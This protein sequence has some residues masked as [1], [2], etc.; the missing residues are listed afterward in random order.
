MWSWVKGWIDPVTADK[1]KFVPGGAALAQMSELMDVEGIPERYGG[2]FEGWHGTLPDLDEGFRCKLEWVNGV[3]QT[4]PI[5]PL[6]WAIDEEVRPI[7][8]AVGTEDGKAR[9]TK[10]ATMTSSIG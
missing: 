5:G 8:L 6:K 9:R 1:I 7:L 2:K 4:I 3:D 10:I